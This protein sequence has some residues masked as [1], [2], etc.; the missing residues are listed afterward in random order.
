M[1][2]KKTRAIAF[3]GIISALCVVFL[4]LGSI[5]EVLDYSVSAL[6]GILVTLVTVEFGNRTGISVWLVSSVLALIILPVK[7]SALLFI[8]FCGWY[9]FVKK[10]LEKFPKLISWIL[11][12]LCFNAVLT[13]IFFIT[14]KFLL[15]EGVGIITGAA[16]VILSN[17]VFII[18]DILL[19][20]LTF[21]Y[22]VSWR[23]RLTFLK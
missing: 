13:V 22:I 4:Y 10:V 16:T 23:K 11:K 6:C 21:L 18:Y 7:F 2:S 8:A 15:I 20:K 5:V 3:S 17:F 9:T 14:V 1:R 19:T 12:L